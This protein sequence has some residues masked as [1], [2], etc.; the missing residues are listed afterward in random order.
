MDKQCNIP[1]RRRY[2]DAFVTA[3]WIPICVAIWVGILWLFDLSVAET[4]SGLVIMLLIPFSFI[5][6]VIGLA[7]ALRIFR[8]CRRTKS[9]ENRA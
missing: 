6:M 9:E 5:F 2:L 1:P 8:E 4:G 7:D 3:S